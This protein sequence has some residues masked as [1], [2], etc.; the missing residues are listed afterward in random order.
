MGKYGYKRSEPMGSV[1]I[2][3]VASKKCNLPDNHSI[4]NKYSNFVL[5]NYFQGELSSCTA[6]AL[7]LAYSYKYFKKTNTMFSPSRLFMYY[8]E[9]MIENTTEYDDGAQLYS[10]VEV[11][12]TIGVCSEDM[13]PYDETKVFDVPNNEC[14][15]SA[16]ANK[17]Q[18]YQLIR[19]NKNVPDY[20]II[21]QLKN[22]LFKDN[23][24]VFGFDV[25][26]N[27]ESDEV[28]KS[29]ILINPSDDDNYLGGHAVTMIGY[30]NNF[31]CY[32]DNN[33][34]IDTHK[35]VSH[36]GA[37][38]CRNSWGNEWGINGNFWIPYNYV[39]GINSYGNTHCSEFWLL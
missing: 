5:P 12:R 10:G 14:Y 22:A 27:F 35:K 25:Y 37:F 26:D 24:I 7:S 18:N 28:K 15:V 2:F 11:L 30:D 21:E 3:K 29:G 38:L 13:Y 34:V 23:P 19:Y 31:D 4:L 32:K 16:S 36:I 33:L 8:N 17:T 39:C 20:Y 1:K 9:R 6:N